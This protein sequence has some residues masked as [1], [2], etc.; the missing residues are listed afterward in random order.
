MG[1]S[2]AL[3][4]GETVKN[5]L[6]AYDFNG[7]KREDNPHMGIY[8]DSSVETAS[9]EDTVVSDEN[10]LFSTD[11]RKGADGMINAGGEWKASKGIYFQNST[12]AARTTVCYKDGFSWK[13][14]EVSADV[15]APSSIEGNS[16]GIIFRSDESMKNMYAFRFLSENMLEFVKWQ[17]NAFASIQKWQYN[18]ETD[19]FYNLKVRAEGDTFTFYVND[20]EVRKVS[21][22]SFLSG[23]VG[24]Y[25]YRES[26]QYDNVKV[27]AID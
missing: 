22:S 23:T 6:L 17:N 9:R 2:E 20:E 10:I 1:D 4:A 19:T 16:T 18:F 14:Y 12:A 21:D 24:F 15:Q 7:K 11:F 8:A 3:N 26:N 13:N 27:V 5:E 25:C